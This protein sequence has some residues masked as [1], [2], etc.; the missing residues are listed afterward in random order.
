[1]SVTLWIRD[2]RRLIRITPS[3]RAIFHVASKVWYL[4]LCDPGASSWLLHFIFQQTSHNILPRTRNLALHV[5]IYQLESIA[6]HYIYPICMGSQGFFSR[7]PRCTSSSSLPPKVQSSPFNGARDENEPRRGETTKRGTSILE[8]S[9]GPRTQCS[10]VNEGARET[11]RE[12]GEKP[13][14]VPVQAAAPRARC[15]SSR[16]PASLSE[17]TETRPTDPDPSTLRS[18]RARCL[19]PVPKIYAVPPFF[20]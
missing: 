17:A 3:L 9:A 15:I 8:L 13:E 20:K 7:C 1:M 10:L 14:P 2:A 4:G 6:V 12:R 19:T 5:Q 16:K 18:L 11:R